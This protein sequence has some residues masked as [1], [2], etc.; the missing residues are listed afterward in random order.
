MEKSDSQSLETPQNKKMHPSCEFGRFD[1][2]ES[3]RDRVSFDGSTRRGLDE[4]YV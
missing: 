1:N 4:K 3:R 2:G